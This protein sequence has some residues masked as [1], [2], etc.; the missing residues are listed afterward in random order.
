MR[1]VLKTNNP[2]LLNYAQVLLADAGIEAVVFDTHASVVDGSLGILPRRVMVADAQQARAEAILRD[3]LKTVP[4]GDRFLGG[5]ITIRQPEQGFRSGLDAVMLAA[6]VPA[7]DGDTTLELGA[8]VGVA[9]LCLAARVEGCAVTGV[10][11]DAALTERATANAFANDLVAT[12]VTA[13]VFALP[14]ELRRDFTHVF[15]NP[16]FHGADG[17]TSPDAA[18]A[19]ALQDDGKLAD[20]LTTGLKRTISN[21]TFTA[22]LRADRL[23]EALAALPDRGV[24]LFPLWAR[25]GE[26]AKRVILR[27]A[28]DSRAPLAM[29]PG[30]VLHESNGDYTDAADDVL[31]EGGALLPPSP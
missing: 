27:V 6:A 17:E 1:E 24:T 7:R 5:R 19:R 12:F 20:W 28:K 22:I 4:D 9:S 18:R 26:P 31:R 15:C 11:I 29:L 8:G 13:D 25:A 2:V 16:P 10:E 21:G 3:G 14:A 23:A 30:L